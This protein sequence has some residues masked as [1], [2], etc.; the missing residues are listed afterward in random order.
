MH[1]VR[2][3]QIRWME[4]RGLVRHETHRGYHAEPFSL[5]EVEELYDLREI[6]ELSLLPKAIERLD[7]KSIKTFHDAYLA[8][9]EA[10]SET[11]LNER[12]VKDI[13]FHITLA[14]LSGCRV[15]L[16]VLINLLDVLCLKYRSSYPSAASF[17]KGVSEH[18][19]VYDAVADRDIGLA[20]KVLTHHIRF[21]KET[22]IERF[23]QI[24]DEK[25]DLGF[26]D[27]SWEKR[28]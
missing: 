26:P 14:S 13:E 1:Q 21:T 23:T 9:A 8:H 19:A 6:L 27:I 10:P 11:Y 18:R 24:M 3:V 7:D 4:I 22:V 16:Q 25:R 12:F 15:Q 5:Q 2:A 28:T 17:E 20:Q